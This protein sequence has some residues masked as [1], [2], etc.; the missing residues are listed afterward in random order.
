MLCWHKCRRSIGCEYREVSHCTHETWMFPACS[1]IGGCPGA[2]VI[3]SSTLSA[4]E[5]S[6]GDKCLAP[7]HSVKSLQKPEIDQARETTRLKNMKLTQTGQDSDGPCTYRTAGDLA[8]HSLPE[9]NFY[10]LQIAIESSRKFLLQE[11]VSI[12]CF[13]CAWH[14]MST[15]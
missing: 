9:P 1:H 7:G 3:C 12:R 8:S 14:I 6:G 11:A 4:R 2:E 5:G 15:Q 13:Y 10:L